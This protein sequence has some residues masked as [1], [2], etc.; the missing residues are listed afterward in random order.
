MTASYPEDQ[1]M[2]A[3]GRETDSNAQGN[4]SPSD[5]LAAVAS[6]RDAN[7]DKWLRTQAEFDNYRKRTQREAEENR[8]YQDLPLIRSLLPALDNLQRA[9]AAG[10]RAHNVDEL[11]QG[12]R[13]VAK[14]I[15]DVFASRSVT[16]IESVG[17]QFDP[18]I[19]EALQQIPTAAQPPMTVLDEAERGY[20]LHDRVVRP[21][22]VI[23]A[24]PP[25]A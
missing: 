22:K 8:K 5:D 16:P 4:S 1:N 25:P 9:I 11:L 2:P 6:E 3:D 18:N 7:Y 17:Q 24:A 13:M 10:E 21:S 23:V 14:Q 19:H 20:R 12:V 15:E